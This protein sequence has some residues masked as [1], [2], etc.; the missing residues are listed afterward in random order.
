MGKVE[1]DGVALRQGLQVKMLE[2]VGAR[3]F[4][5]LLESLTA[6]EPNEGKD[7]SADCGTAGDEEKEFAKGSEDGVGE[8]G[9]GKG[10]GIKAQ[11]CEQSDLNDTLNSLSDALLVPLGVT[12]LFMRVGSVFARNS[13][14]KLE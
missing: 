7:N 9:Q 8:M 13:F 6:M 12:K 10:G 1:R 2:Q 4:A 11:S 5:G 14:Q 3:L